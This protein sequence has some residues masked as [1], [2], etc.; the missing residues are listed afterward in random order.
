MRGDNQT[1]PLNDDFQIFM[2][3]VNDILIEDFFVFDRWGN[4][5]IGLNNINPVNGE[6]LWDGKF[7]NEQL[8]PGVYVYLLKI[9]I[10]GEKIIRKGDITIKL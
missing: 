8:N 5:I 6:I 7:N 3:D 10:N 2:S 4:Q 1:G 9:D